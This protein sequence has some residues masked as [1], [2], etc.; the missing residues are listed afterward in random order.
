VQLRRT[1]NRAAGPLEDAIES[2]TVEGLEKSP[3]ISRAAEAPESRLAVIYHRFKEQ[4]SAILDA[5]VTRG[6]H[7]AGTSRR[8]AGTTGGPS[9]NE[10]KA[11]PAEAATDSLAPDALAPKTVLSYGRKCEIP[12]SD[13]SPSLITEAASVQTS[14]PSTMVKATLFL[15]G[16]LL[17]WPRKMHASGDNAR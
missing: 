7:L 14:A 3:G 1:S 17:F 10:D 8:Q 11:F 4:F 16:L 15:A 12:S 9:R 13:L 6:G 5:F 2:R